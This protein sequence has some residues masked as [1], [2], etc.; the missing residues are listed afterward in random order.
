[1]SRRNLE[2]GKEL[3]DKLGTPADRPTPRVVPA[4]HGV[5]R[6]CDGVVVWATSPSGSRVPLDVHPEGEFVLRDGVAFELPANEGEKRF[7]R[8]V[9]SCR[10][11]RGL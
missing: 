1:V 7:T 5:C 10:E 9:R 6:F 3:L 8:H 11:K 4:G 2:R